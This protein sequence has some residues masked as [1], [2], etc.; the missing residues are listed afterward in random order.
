M[1]ER[2]ENEC[3][4]NGVRYVAQE[5]RVTKCNGCAAEGD[6]VLCFALPQCGPY[7]RHAGNNVIFVAADAE[8]PAAAA[9]TSG[10][11]QP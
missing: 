3:V 10:E 6:D 11:V 4:I 1:S 7:H 5:T 9:V 8:T 2:N